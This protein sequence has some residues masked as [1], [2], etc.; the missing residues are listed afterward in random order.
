MNLTGLEIKPGC[1]FRMVIGRA[2]VKGGRLVKRLFQALFATSTVKMKPILSSQTADIPGNVDRTLKGGTVIMKGP[3][4][5]PPEG[6]QSYQW[7]SEFPWKEKRGCWLTNDGE[8]DRNW[9]LYKSS[10]VMFRS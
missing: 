3:R 7:K 4:R 1:C 5:N 2:N 9:L 6:L 10:A 8:T